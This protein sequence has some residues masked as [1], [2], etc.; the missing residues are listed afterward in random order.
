MTQKKN[1][2]SPSKETSEATRLH[3]P[4]YELVLQAVSQSGAE[5]DKHGKEECLKKEDLNVNSPS[6]KELIKTISIDRYPMRMQCD[7]AT[8]LMVFETTNHYD[9]DHTGYTDFATSSECSACKCQDCKAKHDEAI[10][11]INA[12]TA[13]IKKITSKRGVIPSKRI[14]NPYTPLEIKMAKRRRKEISKESSSIE[15]T[16]IANPLSLSFTFDQC[17]RATGEQHELKKPEVFRTEECLINLIKDFSIPA[18]LPLHLI[19]EVYIPINCG[20]EFH[21]VLV[22]VILK[23]RPIRVY[24]SMLGTRHFAPSSQSTIEVYR[25]KLGNPFDVEYVEGIS[26]QFI[27]SLDCGLFVVAYTKYLS[28]ELQVPNDGLDSGLLRKRYAALL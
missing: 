24:D 23:E 15:K 12:L 8:N 25:D 27:D 20:D 17:T 2:S 16:K 19:E 11:V 22:V 21:W 7:G 4:L 10:N 3:P 6:T 9:Y 13:S 18:G 14:S 5:G 1:E 28:N 26:Q